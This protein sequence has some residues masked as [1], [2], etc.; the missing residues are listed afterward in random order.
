LGEILSGLHAFEVDAIGHAMQAAPGA[1]T[2]AEAYGINRPARVLRSGARLPLD[3]KP[4]FN[5]N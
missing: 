1:V 2:M 4:A 5:G 3:I